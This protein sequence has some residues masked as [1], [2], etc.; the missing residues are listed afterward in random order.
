MTAI[1]KSTERFIATADYRQ[2]VSPDLFG[3]LV[4][5]IVKDEDVDS[6]LAERIAESALGFLYICADHP[7]RLSP[8]PLVDIGWHTFILYTRGYA[9][10]CERFAG[11]FIHHEPNDNLAAPQRSGGIERSIKAIRA[12]G[13]PLDLMLWADNLTPPSAGAAARD[14]R[15]ADCDGG[16][17]GGD[18]GCGDGTGC[19]DA[20]STV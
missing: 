6:G 19:G 8:S 15:S 20:C 10:F 5:R 1:T 9:E 13:L 16:D 4:G 18:S 17:G 7:G 11:R 3:R 14:N 2:L 12:A